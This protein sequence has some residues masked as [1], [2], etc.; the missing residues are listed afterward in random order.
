MRS[1]KIRKTNPVL[2]S[3]IVSYFFLNWL[4]NLEDRADNMS[5][6][7]KKNIKK[8]RKKA[9]IYYCFANFFAG[10]KNFKHLAWI[11]LF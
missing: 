10:F 3:C 4:S 9:V 11:S 8:I 2:T 5:S 6:L 1:Q 7:H